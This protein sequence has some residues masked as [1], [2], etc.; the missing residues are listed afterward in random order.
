M[1]VKY[2]HFSLSP[3]RFQYLTCF[4]RHGKIIFFAVVVNK[5]CLSNNMLLLV[6]KSMKLK[7]LQICNTHFNA[8]STAKGGGVSTSIGSDITLK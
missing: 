4:Y 8:K 1:H 5:I 3:V 6:R 7:I 2:K